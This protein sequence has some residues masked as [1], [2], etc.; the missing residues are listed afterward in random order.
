MNL[1]SL[2]AFLVTIAFMLRVFALC[3][4]TGQ[5]ISDSHFTSEWWAYIW[6]K[7]STSLFNF[8]MLSFVSDVRLRGNISSAGRIEVFHNGRWGTVCGRNFPLSSAR[9]VCR[10]LGFLDVELVV[11]CCSIFPSGRGRILLDDVRCRG[12]EPALSMCSHKGWGVSSC[13]HSQDIGVIC[14]TNTTLRSGMYYQYLKGS[15]AEIV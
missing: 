15:I 6:N 7:C 13:S 10:Q 8:P 14:R 3:S 12:D 11:R 5:S 2:G 4:K 1:Y 9:V